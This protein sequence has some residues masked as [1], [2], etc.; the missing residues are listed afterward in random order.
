MPPPE[1]KVY[2]CPHTQPLPAPARVGRGEAKVVSSD[3]VSGLYL[4]TQTVN[5]L[6]TKPHIK[7]TSTAMGTL[8]HRLEFRRMRAGLQP[9]NTFGIPTGIPLASEDRMHSSGLEYTCLLQPFR[10]ATHL[11]VFLLPAQHTD[12]TKNLNTWAPHQPVS[13]VYPD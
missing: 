2:P 1:P 6:K 13:L 12:T 8:W 5:A 4:H 10:C 7:Q 9:R 3:T 11:R